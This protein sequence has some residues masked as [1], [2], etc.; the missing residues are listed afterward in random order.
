MSLNIH[1]LHS[2]LDLF[3]QNCNAVSGEHEEH[4]HQDI[5]VMENIIKGSG[6]ST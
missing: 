3:P 4:F 2:R 6:A 1:F 5:P